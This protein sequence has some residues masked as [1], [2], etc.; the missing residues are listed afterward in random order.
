MGIF[1]LHPTTNITPLACATFMAV[2]A[3]LLKNS[4]STE[5]ASGLYVSIMFSKSLFNFNNLSGNDSPASVS[6]APDVTS[7]KLFPL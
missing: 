7:L 6:T 2:F 3:L 4:S 5:I 1:F